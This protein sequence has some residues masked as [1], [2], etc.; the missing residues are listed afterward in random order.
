MPLA[1]AAGAFVATPVAASS[2]ESLQAKV[3]SENLTPSQIDVINQHVTLGNL[4]VPWSIALFVI[5]A[6]MYWIDWKQPSWP[7]LAVKS[8]PSLAVVAALGSIVM[9]GII[10]H[11]GASAVWTQVQALPSAPGYGD[12]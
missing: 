7:A 1:F 12:G 5:A 6:A 10:G 11:S 4:L 3:M 8:L 9:L 2:G